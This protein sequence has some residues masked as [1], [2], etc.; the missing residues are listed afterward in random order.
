MSEENIEQ[1]VELR[2]VTLEE[3]LEFCEA[4]SEGEVVDLNDAHT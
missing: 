2:V 1:D 3:V 4:K